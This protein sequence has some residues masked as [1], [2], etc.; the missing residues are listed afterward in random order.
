MKNAKRRLRVRIEK[1]LELPDTRSHEVKEVNG[2]KWYK[3]EATGRWFFHDVGAVEYDKQSMEWWGI[4]IYRKIKPRRKRFEEMREA[5]LW[6][7]EKGGEPWQF[8]RAR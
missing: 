6:V 7:Q 5:M 4:V 1:D 3:S 2:T 8:Y